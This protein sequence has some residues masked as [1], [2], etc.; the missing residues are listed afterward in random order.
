MRDIF[1]YPTGTTRYDPAVNGGKAP[2]GAAQQHH[3][4]A[5]LPNGNTVVL[6]NAVRRIR[7]SN[8]P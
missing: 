7:A 8:P 3:D 2:G 5:R 6:A 4:W 1:G